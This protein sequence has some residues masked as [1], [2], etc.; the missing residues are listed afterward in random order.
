MY[1]REESMYKKGV[2]VVSTVY[3]DKGD[4]IQLTI[5]A[6]AN[7]PKGDASYRKH[8]LKCNNYKYYFFFFFH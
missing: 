2:R 6:D 5:E 7:I 3:S 8:V 1:G 4:N